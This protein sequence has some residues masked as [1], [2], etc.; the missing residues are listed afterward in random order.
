VNVTS[1]TADRG[2]HPFL[3]AHRAGNRLADLA[4]AE[5]L[6]VE[7]I[8]AD[9]RLFR[10]RLEVRHLKTVGPLPILWDRWEL[11]AP[12][13]ARLELDELLEATAETTELL[14]DLKGL[15]L[16]LAERVR[17]AIS[18]FLDTRTF[19]LCA[20]NW[21]LLAPFADLPVR[22][23]HSVGSE[24]QL[25]RLLRRVGE[26]R[27]EGISIHQRLLDRESVAVVR[28]AAD[29]VM[30]WPVNDPERARELLGLGVDGLITDDPHRLAA[31]G[32]LE[33]TA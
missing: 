33:A 30:T 31:A 16:E 4:A 2:L 28:A 19:T 18:P 9:V 24:R 27:L 29:F 32:V 13:R 1:T 14:L 17:E 25:R 15:R 11:A 23:V 8:E 20:R 21:R 10:D 12:W 3:I 6:G 22:R 26:G 7:L 5:E